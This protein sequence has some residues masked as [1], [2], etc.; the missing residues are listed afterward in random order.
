MYGN[1]FAEPGYRAEKLSFAVTTESPERILPLIT[2]M[3]ADW[4][5]VI[6]SSGYLVIGNPELAANSNEGLQWL[7]ANC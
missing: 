4:N 1:G 5:R 6:G 3:G 7:M 2:L